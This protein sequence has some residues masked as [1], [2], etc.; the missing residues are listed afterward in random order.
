MTAP[1]YQEVK[2]VEIPEV[3]DDDGTRARIELPAAFASQRTD[4]RSVTRPG[5]ALATT[6][7][8]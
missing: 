2:A 4:P 6:Y 3:T 7:P 8:W 1:R 5:F